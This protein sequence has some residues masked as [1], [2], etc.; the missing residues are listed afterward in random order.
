MLKNILNLFKSKVSSDN[1]KMGKITYVNYKRGFGFITTRE[2]VDKIFVHVSDVQ[3]NL[4]KGTKVQFK[5]EKNKQGWRAMD[6]TP[7]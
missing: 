7:V 3:G 5:L 2:L 6:V 4:K 1:I